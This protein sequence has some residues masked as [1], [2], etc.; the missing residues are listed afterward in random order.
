MREMPRLFPS[1]LLQVK[2]KTSQF[3]ESCEKFRDELI[4]NGL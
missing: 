2:I 4:I 3:A 1:K